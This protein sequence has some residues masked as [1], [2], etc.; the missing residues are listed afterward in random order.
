M[1][2]ETNKQ[3]QN[4]GSRYFEIK[5]LSTEQSDS[6]SLLEAADAYIKAL[7]K[8]THSLAVELATHHLTRFPRIKD[9]PVEEQRPFLAWLQGQTCPYL[10]GV[11][12]E[13][14][15]GYYIHDYEA[16]R[17]SLSGEKVSW[18]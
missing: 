9:L 3:V 16:W 15:D 10:K 13:E 2:D 18:D 5:Y 4:A 17:Q 1:S 7:E 8:H 6:A 14:Q 11:P 12:Y